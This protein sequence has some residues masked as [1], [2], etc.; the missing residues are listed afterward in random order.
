[1]FNQ[2]LFYLNCDLHLL[3]KVFY[4][5]LVIVNSSPCASDRCS[6]LLSQL[7]QCI[8]NSHHSCPYLYF[9]SLLETKVFSAGWGL[10]EDLGSLLL[11]FKTRKKC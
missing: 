11:I 9:S 2:I 8:C 5:A 3:F 1:M 7:K 4:L 10:T 6:G